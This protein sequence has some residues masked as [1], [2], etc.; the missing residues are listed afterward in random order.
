VNGSGDPQFIDVETII[1]N[2]GA[3]AGTYPFSGEITTADA[4]GGLSMADA[5]TMF[6]AS[7][8][9]ARG[10]MVNDTSSVFT[11]NQD[12]FQL[13]VVGTVPDSGTTAV[14]KLR[15]R[16]ASTRSKLRGR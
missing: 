4:L 12:R 10:C 6:R 3:G 15:S 8:F 2:G 14:S 16:W 13:R 11:L 7:T 1:N 9:L 5:L